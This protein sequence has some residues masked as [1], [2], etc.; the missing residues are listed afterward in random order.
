MG[1]RQNPDRVYVRRNIEDRFMDKVEMCPMSGCWLWTAGV[2]HGGYVIFQRGIGQGS[3]LA[4]RMA[5]RMY[6]ND[7]ID[8][9]V[10]CHKCD[11]PACVNPN[12][13]WEGTHQEN[14]A[15]MVRKG[16]HAWR[17]K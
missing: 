12:H 2:N 16:R 1:T 9:V 14:H 3:I 5:Y 8:G 13:V 4:H 15:D 17:N 11:T 10:L 6:V 7:K